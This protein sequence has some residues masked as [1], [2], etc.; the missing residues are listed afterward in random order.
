MESI[1]NTNVPESET[2]AETQTEETKEEVAQEEEVPQEERE[3][4]KTVNT[5]WERLDEVLTNLEETPHQ[6]HTR[7][8]FKSALNQPKQIFCCSTQDVNR[9]INGILQGSR[10]EKQ[11]V[12]A[13]FFDSFRVSFTDRSLLNVKSIQLYSAS[14]PM[15]QTN[16]TNAERRF[17]FYKIPTLLSTTV[18]TW[19]LL[20]VYTVSQVV[21]FNGRYYGCYK[22]I[23]P[24]V[25]PNPSID[26]ARWYDAGTDGTDPNW[27]VL[28]PTIRG[29][30]LK[31]FELEPSY[32]PTENTSL[33]DQEKYGWNKV[34]TDY[35]D[36]L[37]EVNR[38]AGYNAI[39]QGTGIDEVYF[40]FNSRMNK[41]QIFPIV[42]DSAYYVLPPFSDTVYQAANDNFPLSLNLRLGF[43]EQNDIPDVLSSNPWTSDIIADFDQTVVGI[44]TVAG[45][46]Y[47]EASSYAN[48]NYS[49]RCNIFADVVRSS[50]FDTFTGG[51]LLASVPINAGNLGVILYQA[52]YPNK[53]INV[54]PEIYDIFFYFETDNKI[55]YLFP[56]SAT[57]SLELALEY[58]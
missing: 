16:I 1:D 58:F 14:L 50:S 28:A 43:S 55:P 42:Q 39:G 49:N 15:A 25:N 38:A 4:I 3:P 6:L 10:N 21:T 37:T 22:T 53:L 32:E 7:D 57:I 30:Y 11:I 17:W 26:T 45:N 47:R 44:A 8:V 27:L 12:S 19:T 5:F 31:Y 34:F 46:G 52:V 56:K 29:T 18:G 33:A 13:G 35:Q 2:L 40:Q 20:T 24:G 54:P 9:G 48:L 51:E 36:L 41:F 23:P